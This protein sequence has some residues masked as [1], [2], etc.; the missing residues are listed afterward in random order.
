MILSFMIVANPQ[1]YQ[2]T[3]SLLGSWVATQ[4]GTAKLA[5]LFLH[6]LVFVFLVKLLKKIMYKK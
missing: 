4:D 1:T 3:R 5:G 2:V 6:A